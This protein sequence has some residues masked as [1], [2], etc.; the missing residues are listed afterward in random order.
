MRLANR[1][2]VDRTRLMSEQSGETCAPPYTP[3]GGRHTGG[4]TRSWPLEC[5]GAASLFQCVFCFSRPLS[6]TP[7]ALA[8]RA[9]A[10]WSCEDLLD[11]GAACDCQAGNF[12]SAE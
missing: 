11:C 2:V 12:D 7:G 4:G 8:D 10:C 1:A 6:R 5:S 9:L 3:C